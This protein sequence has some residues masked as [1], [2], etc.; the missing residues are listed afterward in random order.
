MGVDGVRRLVDAIGADGL[1]LHLNAGA[2]ADPARGRPR[3]PRRLQPWCRRWRGLRRAPA[4]EGDRLRHLA[5]RWRGGWSSCGVRT[6]D[7][8]GLGGTSWVRVE[9]L[10]AAGHDAPRS[11]RAF[12]GW[13]I[14]TAAAVATR[15][16][17]GGPGGAAG[18]LGRNA[19]WPGRGEGAGARRG[20][21]GHGA[22][23]VPRAADGRRG[24]RGR[25]AADRGRRAA[26]GAAC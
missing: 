1:A 7:V 16:A 19:H 5:R 20:P 6:I 24:G 11:A 2:G 18:R 17:G 8:S 3:L 25:G 15:A 12:S 14:P 22:A 9:Q 4:G 23:A 21:G 13:G 10:R 26:A